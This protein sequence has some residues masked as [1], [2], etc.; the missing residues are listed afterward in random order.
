MTLR[1]ALEAVAIGVLFSF[2][3]LAEAMQSLWPL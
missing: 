3:F 1:E 2:P